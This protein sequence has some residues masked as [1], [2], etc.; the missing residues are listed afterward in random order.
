MPSDEP[1][2]F[3]HIGRNKAGST[4]L[5]DFF[6]AHAQWLAAHGVR[7]SLFGHESEARPDLPGYPSHLHLLEAL[8]NARGFSILVSNEW[9]SALPADL[10]EPMVR[11]LAG[12]RVLVLVYIRP[13]RDWIVS[14]YGNDV[15][16]G[17]NGRDFDSYLERLAARISVWRTLRLWGEG[18][19]WHRVRVRSLD[20]RDL[21]GG[22][23]QDCLAAMGLPHPTGKS[24]RA[25]NENPP[26]T[27]IELLRLAAVGPDGDGWNEDQLA[28]AAV[29]TDLVHRATQSCGVEIPRATYLTR[30]QAEWLAAL[31]N[32]DLEQ[33]AAHTGVQLQPDN[34]DYAR[35]RPFLPTAAHIPIE[36]LRDI[37]RRAAHP[38]Y[39]GTQGVAAFMDARAFQELVCAAGAG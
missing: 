27:A 11:D 9:I 37:A 18:L 8:R 21:Q 26:W 35:P 33:I 14:C 30:P 6:V 39:A 12:A 29:L 22:L 7:Y 15:R 17:F 24:P 38:A 31:Y 1:T 32:H 2:L 3:L 19:G 36:I 28:L 10:V 4:T 34:L 25:S 5:Q 13:Y 20:P 23:T 16:R